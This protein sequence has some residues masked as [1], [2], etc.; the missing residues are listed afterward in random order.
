MMDFSAEI[1]SVVDFAAK[2]NNRIPCVTRRVAKE[3]GMKKKDTIKHDGELL[4]YTAENMKDGCNPV[5]ISVWV[6]VQD[7]FGVLNSSGRRNL[8]SYI[9]A[10]LSFGISHGIPKGE[11]TISIGVIHKNVEIRLG[12][13]ESAGDK[14]KIDG[15]RE[16]TFGN[17][18][19]RIL[20]VLFL[21]CTEV[22]LFCIKTITADDMLDL[23]TRPWLQH[24]VW[25]AVLAC[26]IWD[27]VPFLEK[28]G[29]HS[30]AV[31][32]LETI[33]QGKQ[34]NDLRNNYVVIEKNIF[35][36]NSLFATFVECLLSQ[37]TSGKD[38]VRLVIN[39]GHV[40]RKA[41]HTHGVENIDSG[42][43]KPKTR[44][45]LDRKKTKTKTAI[46]SIYQ[47]LT[48]IQILSKNTLFSVG[49]SIPF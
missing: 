4:E 40:F 42:R 10:L 47:G 44:V 13:F 46:R 28:R 16:D 45:Q 9:M 39:S 22:L 34:N 6:Q 32:M 3:S 18:A 37:R 7:T 36:H 19:E 43:T 48:E 41:K 5:T 29:E 24:M 30:L 26:A 1:R 14:F 27:C 49:G 15:S 21:I 25:D 35:D 12:K 17:D 11:I 33:L 2:M 8:I 23:T 31:D 20:F 38:Y